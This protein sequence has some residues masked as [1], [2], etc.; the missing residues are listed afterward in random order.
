MEIIL[1]RRAQCES[2]NT[3]N[4]KGHKTFAQ[5][6]KRKDDRKKIKRVIARNTHNALGYTDKIKNVYD[7]RRD[8]SRQ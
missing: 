6:K 5:S 1:M 7:A 8:L 4:N 3:S 2:F